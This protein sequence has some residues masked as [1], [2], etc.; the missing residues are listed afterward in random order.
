M[1]NELLTKLLNLWFTDDKPQFQL[2]DSLS[3]FAK[4]IIHGIFYGEDMIY[5]H[6][7]INEIIFLLK[8]YGIIEYDKTIKDVYFDG[9]MRFHIEM[10]DSFNSP[11]G[12]ALMNVLGDLFKT[13]MNAI[14]TQL[15]EEKNR[16]AIPELSRKKPFEN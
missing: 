1:E 13:I 4:T 7:K 3:K 8:D 12:Q 9:K 14:T 11:E 6:P 16:S 10:R 15:E 2:T 5:S